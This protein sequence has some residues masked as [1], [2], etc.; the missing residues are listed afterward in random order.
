MRRYY[1]P[2][3]GILIISTAGIY[4]C[5]E[6]RWKMDAARTLMD[7]N[8]NEKSKDEI[9]RRETRNFERVREYITGGSGERDISKERAIKSFGAPVLTFSQGEWEKWAYKP[10]T[11]SWFKGE[12]IYLYF[13]SKDR[14]VSWECVDIECPCP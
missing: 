2:I 14:L 3:I 5:A 9:F 11:S 8:N 13:D 12:K 10:S 6:L 4:G 1:W 7:L